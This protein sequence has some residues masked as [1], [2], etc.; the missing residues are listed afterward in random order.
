[1]NPEC[2][3]K[4]GAGVFTSVKNVWMFLCLIQYYP[5]NIHEEKYHLFSWMKETKGSWGRFTMPDNLLVVSALD[6]RYFASTSSHP[7]CQP[8]RNRGITRALCLVE[9]SG[10]TVLNYGFAPI[11]LSSWHCGQA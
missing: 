8:H 3:K 11:A 7:V 9:M 5:K 1:M 6:S 4:R 10:S 2:R